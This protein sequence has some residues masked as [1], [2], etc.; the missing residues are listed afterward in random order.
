MCLLEIGEVPG[1]TPGTQSGIFN[2][3]RPFINAF[4]P[5]MIRLIGNLKTFAI[6]EIILLK[7][8]LTFSPLSPAETARQTRK[9]IQELNLVHGKA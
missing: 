6:P 4:I 9:A 1:P 5:S 8:F 3:L 7:I 2:L